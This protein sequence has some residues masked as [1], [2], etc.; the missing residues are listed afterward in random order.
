MTNEEEVLETLNKEG[1]S[2]QT[3][4]YLVALML[5]RILDIIMKKTSKNENN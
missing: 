3:S 4:T 1:R 5:A 2:T